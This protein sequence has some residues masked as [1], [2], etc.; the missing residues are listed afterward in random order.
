VNGLAAQVTIDHADKGDLLVIDGSAGFDFIDAHGLAAGHIGLQLFGRDGGDVLI[1]SAGNDSLEGGTGNDELDGGLGND[2]FRYSSPLDGHD[3]IDNFDGNASG[4]QD[5]LNLD[6]LF[7]GLGVAAAD[8]A[9]RV[10]IADHG[11][12]VDVAIDLDGN[13]ANGFE[14]TAATL[15]LG[16]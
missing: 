2:S 9:G 3:V 4:G 6:A 7:D 8:R 15:L 13:T 14:L 10:A 5:T 11:A 1:G 12:T 16:T